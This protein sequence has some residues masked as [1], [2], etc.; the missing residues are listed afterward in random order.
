MATPVSVNFPETVQDPGHFARKKG[1]DSLH[2]VERHAA[3]KGFRDS[4]GDAG[5]GVGVPPEGNGTPP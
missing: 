5:L 1:S 3:V 4:P 2:Q